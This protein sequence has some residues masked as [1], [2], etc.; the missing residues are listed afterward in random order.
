MKSYGFFYLG[1]S[2][3]EVTRAGDIHFEF[4]DLYIYCV[5]SLTTELYNHSQHFEEEA[6]ENCL[7]YLPD[8]LM[9]ALAEQETIYF[10]LYQKYFSINSPF[11]LGFI[12]QHFSNI[13]HYLLRQK[14]KCLSCLPVTIT[15]LMFLECSCYLLPISKSFTNERRLTLSTS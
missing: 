7:Q 11:L 13:S 14:N 3:F 9:V 12:T 10:V 4:H 8:L 15:T 1:P 6:G 5:F 2:I